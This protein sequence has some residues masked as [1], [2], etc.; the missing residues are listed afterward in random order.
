[1][2]I[3][4]LISM[5]VLSVCVYEQWTIIETEGEEDCLQPCNKHSLS[6][7]DNHAYMHAYMHMCIHVFMHAWRDTTQP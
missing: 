1:M 3:L 4:L 5:K 6:S 2:G 7:G